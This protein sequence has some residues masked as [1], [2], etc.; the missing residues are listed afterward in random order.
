MVSDNETCDLSDSETAL[1][2]P[3][4]ASPFVRYPCIR[5]RVYV[6]V[7]TYPFTFYLRTCGACLSRQARFFGHIMRVNGLEHQVTT[8]KI[9]GKRS[10]GRQRMKH[11]DG[12]TKCTEKERLNE[13][14]HSGQDRIEWRAMMVN[15]SRHDT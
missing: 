10:R 9:N 12:L 6:S 1:V 13:V 2:S 7:Y 11:L 3:K 4:A 8:G 5:I 14:I 15:A